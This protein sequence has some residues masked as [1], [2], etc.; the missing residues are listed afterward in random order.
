MRVIQSPIR[1]LIGS[2][3]SEIRKEIIMA[4]LSMFLA[5]DQEN[6]KKELDCYDYLLTNAIELLIKGE[7]RQ[8]AIY[9]YNIA[10]SL[11]ELGTLRVNK[12]VSDEAK[13]LLRQIEKQETTR[14]NWF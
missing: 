6:A 11:E 7:F 9:H 10:R 13:E 2:I 12:I 4:N 8:A 3:L 1:I 5:K 14:R